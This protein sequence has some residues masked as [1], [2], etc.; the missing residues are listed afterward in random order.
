[1][2][3]CNVKLEADNYQEDRSTRKLVCRNIQCTNKASKF[4]IALQIPGGEKSTEV[5]SQIFRQLDR[6]AQVL[7]DQA[8][9]FNTSEFLPKV[10]LCSWKNN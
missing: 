3:D 4:S 6:L 10:F 9:T 5:I 2:T 1:M 7:S 8:L